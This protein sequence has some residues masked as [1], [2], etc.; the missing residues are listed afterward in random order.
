[1]ADGR[2]SDQ[3]QHTSGSNQ[4]PFSNPGAQDFNSGFSNQ[5]NAVSQMFKE[6]GFLSGDRKTRMI[7]MIAVLLAVFGGLYF[8]MT[9]N[10][11]FDEDFLASGNLEQEDNSGLSDVADEDEDLGD[12]EEGGGGVDK[13]KKDEVVQK[14]KMDKKE[15]DADAEDED[16]DEDGSEDL[17]DTSSQQEDNVAAEP[18]GEKVGEDLAMANKT[19]GVQL[20]NTAIKI[21][22][23]QDNFER[24][25]DETAEY[26]T[27]KWEGGP[28]GWIYLSKNPSMKPVSYKRRIVGNEYK[29]RKLFPGKWYWQ[30]RN[31][32][33]ATEVRSFT[34]LEPIP[35]QMSIASPQDGAQIGQNSMVTWQGDAKISY[36]RIELSNSDDWSQPVRFATSGTQIRLKGVQPGSYKMRVGGFSEVSGKWEY[37]QPISVQVQ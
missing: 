36:Y 4:N 2:N 18:A 8:Y 20:P 24:R 33:G 15:D 32:K 29:F 28:R 7:V 31:E 6:G 35:R 17:A 23:P 37:Q 1:M 11:N 26:A 30:A 19:Q 3:N 27:F 16:L 22:S 21:I 25:F 10:D 9:P 14:D 13:N 12:E 34:I 5:S